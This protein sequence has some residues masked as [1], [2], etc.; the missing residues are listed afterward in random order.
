MISKKIE[1]VGFLLLLLACIMLSG[2]KNTV[3]L[4]EKTSAKFSGLLETANKDGINLTIYYMKPNLLT[5]YPISVDRLIESE[6]SEKFEISCERLKENIPLIEKINTIDLTKIVSS[7]E[8]LYLNA[9]IYFVIK[10]DKEEKLFDVAMWGR[11]HCMLVNGVWIRESQVLYNI[12]LAF[13]PTSNA[14]ELQE[15]LSNS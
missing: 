15:Y 8:Y 2:C 3:H 11:Y 13:L 10:T 6:L 5:I 4:P 14:Q 1:T 7:D 9:R 12:L